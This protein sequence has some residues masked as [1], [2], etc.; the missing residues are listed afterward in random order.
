MPDRPFTFRPRASKLQAMS[1]P[2]QRERSA[3][4]ILVLACVLA[5]VALTLLF[6]AVPELADDSGGNGLF[7]LG[8]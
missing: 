4:V 3:P 5:T 7:W 1:T 6:V 2:E 8:T